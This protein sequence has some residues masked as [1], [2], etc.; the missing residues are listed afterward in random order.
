MIK[1]VI[2]SCCLKRFFFKVTVNLNPTGT[3]KWSN[4][5]GSTLLHYSTDSR[6]HIWLHGMNKM[7]KFF[8]PFHDQGANTSAVVQ[9]H[10]TY[11]LLFWPIIY[12]NKISFFWGFFSPS[13]SGRQCL[14][15]VIYRIIPVVSDMLYTFTLC[16]YSEATSERGTWTI[17]VWS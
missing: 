15:V 12:G 14:T 2:L 17:A 10:H 4:A 3:R 13:F 5:F 1:T 9:V 8:V 6:L 7:L 11:E 16:R